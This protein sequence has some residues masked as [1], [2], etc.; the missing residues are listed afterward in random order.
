MRSRK[1]QIIDGLRGLFS[2]KI[3]PSIIAGI[4][5]YL[6]EHVLWRLYIHAD[7]GVRIHSSASIR[8]ARNVF[9]G[10]NSHINHLCSVWAGKNARIVLGENVLM[11][12]GVSIQA[13]NH[14]T[15]KGVLMNRQA[16]SEGDI[17]IGDDVWIGSNVTI[18]SGVKIGRG[19][20]IGAGAVVTK[21][22]P[23]YAIAGGVPA[24]VIRFRE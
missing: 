16:E 5:Y 22:V 2:G 7:R 20:V 21:D 14:G 9:V 12:P 3:I 6:H 13:A 23:E 1:S 18:L 8:N 4:G 15:K 19:A 24:K 10:V 17:L 11:G